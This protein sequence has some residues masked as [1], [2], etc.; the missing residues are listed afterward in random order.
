MLSIMSH[1]SNFKVGIPVF[2][3]AN[4]KVDEFSRILYLQIVTWKLRKRQL[5][6][7]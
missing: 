7:D 3:K 6:H 2:A 5:F 4:R 1:V